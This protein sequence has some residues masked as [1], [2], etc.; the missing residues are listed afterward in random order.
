MRSGDGRNLDV[1]AL[2]VTVRGGAGGRY[3]H[4]LVRLGRPEAPLRACLP[5]DPPPGQAK[6]AAGGPIYPWIRP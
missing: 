2:D 3:G 1:L 6:I 4:I 5:L